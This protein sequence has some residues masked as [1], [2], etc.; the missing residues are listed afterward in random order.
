MS[1][2][3]V[4]KSVPASCQTESVDTLRLDRNTVVRALNAD[5]CLGYAVARF[6]LGPLQLAWNPAGTR[7]DR[8]D[9]VGPATI[10]YERQHGEITARYGS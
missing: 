8:R 3:S 10:T 9:F 5:E 1:V 7:G 6:R 4:I 2:I